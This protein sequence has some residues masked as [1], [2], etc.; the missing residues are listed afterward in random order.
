MA[1]LRTEDSEREEKLGQHTVLSPLR[2]REKN[3]TGGKTK[4]RKHGQVGYNERE[5]NQALA[6]RKRE[7][8]LD[9]RVCGWL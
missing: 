3:W 6:S 9:K 8:K 7:I 1:T 5:D 4:R 2:V